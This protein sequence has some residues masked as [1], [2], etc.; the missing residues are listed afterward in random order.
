MTFKY[1]NSSKWERNR[2]NFGI[3]FRFPRSKAQSHANLTVFSQLKM[4]H[5]FISNLDS[6][7]WQGKDVNG[8]R[9]QRNRNQPWAVQI[10]LK[11]IWP[12]LVGSIPIW[13]TRDFS[14]IMWQTSRFSLISWLTGSFHS[15]QHD[16]GMTWDQW[17]TPSWMVFVLSDPRAGPAS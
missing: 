7:L 15:R 1:Q 11:S 12:G 2:I 10:T 5:M 16:A 17:R 6:H 8:T 13:N 4:T 14:V 9:S 3:V